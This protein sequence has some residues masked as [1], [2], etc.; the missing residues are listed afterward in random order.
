MPSKILQDI[1]I[2]NESGAVVFDRVY[3]EKID[4]QLFGAL[5]SALNSFAEELT[6]GGL[7]NFELSDKKFTITKKHKYIF[8]VNSDPK[9]KPK[10]VQ[11]E[12][13]VVI[14]KFF[15]KYT[16]DQLTNWD[17]ELTIFEDFKNDIE[18]SLED[19]IKKMQ[20]AFW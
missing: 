8:V 19:P 14:D 11:Y 20:K 2:L 18:D 10:K 15:E 3:D 17:G 4:P 7:S 6:E 9:I 16:K 5:M 12:L 1:W 13:Q